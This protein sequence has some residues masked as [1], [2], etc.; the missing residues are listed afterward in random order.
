MKTI[1]ILFWVCVAMGLI[2]GNLPLENGLIFSL[3]GIAII[4]IIIIHQ[5]SY[6]Q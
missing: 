1:I 6:G 4:N 5:I 2:T 3:I